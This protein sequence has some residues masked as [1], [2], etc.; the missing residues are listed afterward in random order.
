MTTDKDETVDLIATYLV[1]KLN[2]VVE[3]NERYSGA[4]RQLVR[5]WQKRLEEAK[6]DLIANGL[7]TQD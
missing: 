3:S 1:Y 4:Q 6:R 7:A 5:K 2:L